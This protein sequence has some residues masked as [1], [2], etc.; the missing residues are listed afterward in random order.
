MDTVY[1]DCPMGISGDMFLGAMIDLGV[2]LG[3][4]IKT[5]EKLP[6]DSGE[7]DIVTSKEVRH[8]I[9]GTSFKVRVKESK[10]HRSYRA[11]KSMIQKSAFP[12]RVEEL[13]IAIFDLI[14]Q[15]EGRIH[16]VPAEDV[17]FHEIGAMDSI[18]DIIGAAVAVDSLGSPSF[19][20]SPVAL[21]EGM[22][23]TMHGTIPIPAPATLDI[24]KGVPTVAGPAPFELTT[25]TGAAIIKTLAEGFGP[26]PDMVLD[27]T[28][29][30]AGKK[31]FDGAANLL[32]IITGTMSKKAGVAERLIMF[33]TTIDDMSPEIGGWLMEKLLAKGA[34]DVF[35]TPAQMK[36]S[37]PG[38]LLGVLAKEE[39]KEAVLDTIFT[40]STT[41]GVRT[42]LVER[43]CLARTIK[44]VK[45]EYGTISVKV[46]TRQGRTI[47]IQPEYEDCK[48]IAQEQGIP[49]KTIMAAASACARIKKK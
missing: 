15:S 34:L 8:S 25:P 33:E 28:G 49:L 24:L 45:T 43:H 16:G 26:M 7:F 38:T 36:K 3:L 47:N 10:H 30:G 6:I 20:A 9:T 48:K 1:I 18:I 46:S 31:D 19:F 5:L 13:S 42:H 12:P 17:H 39:D 23:K 11:I 14:A 21:G 32:R 35:Y 2:E 37:R 27:A 44:E 29:Y 4:I 22:A 40:E 41:I